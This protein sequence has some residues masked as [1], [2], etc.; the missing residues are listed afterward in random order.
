MSTRDS[1]AFRPATTNI[2]ICEKGA[3]AIGEQV[4][5]FD[6]RIGLTALE[7]ES[8]LEKFDGFEVAGGEVMG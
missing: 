6:H 3:S 1:N 8:H 4:K 2:P 5:V 7:N